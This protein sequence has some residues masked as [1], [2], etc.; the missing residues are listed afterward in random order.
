MRAVHA[1]YSQACIASPTR[2]AFIV[3]SARDIASTS[4]RRKTKN[5]C[6]QTTRSQ[7]HAIGRR[8]NKTRSSQRSMHLHK[9]SHRKGVNSQGHRNAKKGNNNMSFFI[10]E[11]AIVDVDYIVTAFPVNLE[12]TGEFAEENPFIIALILNIG[13]EGFR[14]AMEYP[15]RLRRDVAFEALTELLKRVGRE[16]ADATALDEE[17]PG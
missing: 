16:P 3:A 8:R 14:T 7:R 12:T 5:P 1:E 10:D 6:A 9:N 11:Y 4:T 17:D 15:S 13:E 2:T